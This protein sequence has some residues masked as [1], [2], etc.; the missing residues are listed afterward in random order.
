MKPAGQLT[1]RIK[2]ALCAV[3]LV[4]SLGIAGT[5]IVS[6]ANA[7]Q[8]QAGVSVAGAAAQDDVQGAAA[9]T[10]SGDSAVTPGSDGGALPGDSASEGPSQ[11]TTPENPAGPG[12]PAEPGDSTTPTDPTEPVDPVNPAEPSEPT[13]PTDPADPSQPT[14][15]AK[16]GE[17]E[18]PVDPANP[19]QPTT[20]TG[21]T[22]PGGPTVPT[23]PAN[24]NQ[25]A[26]PENPSTP[27]APADAKLAGACAFKYYVVTHE[28]KTAY[29]T[30]SEALAAAAPARAS[31]GAALKVA[32][33]A[34]HDGEH[35]GTAMGDLAEADLTLALTQQLQ[36][37]V[38]DV[39]GLSVSMLRSS[40]Q[41]AASG[42]SAQDE[43][44]A[45]IALAK[46]A[47]ADLLL[48]VH[49]NLAGGEL[50]CELPAAQDGMPIVVVELALPSDFEQYDFA[51]LGEAVTQMLAGT[52]NPAD[53]NAD[54]S[55]AAAVSVTS[56][57][58]A[59]ADV[60][61]QAGDALST[62]AATAPVKVGTATDSL[63]GEDDKYEARFPDTP[64]DSWY[65]KGGYIDYVVDNG[66]MSGYSATGT[67][68]PDDGISREQVVTILYRYAKGSAS[69][70]ATHFSDVETGQWYTA[71]VE[72]A[73]ENGISTGYFATSRFG[74]G[75]PITR[76]D[77]A[78]ML[79][80]FAQRCGKGSGS[81]DISGFYDSDQVSEYAVDAMEWANAAGI[82][83]GDTTTGVALLNPQAPTTRAQ[84]AKMI[85]VLS[86]DVLAGATM[87]QASWSLSGL[88]TANA[89]LKAGSST[90]ATANVSG[91]GS[92]LTYQFAWVCSD[93]ST[94][95][96]DAASSSSVD[97]DFDDPGKYTVYVKVTDAYGAAHMASS[98]VQVWKLERAKVGS[99]GDASW[100][101][102]AV[103]DAP[104]TE[105][106]SFKYTWKRGWAEGSATL[107]GSQMGGESLSVTLPAEDY[108]WFYAKVIDPEGHEDYRAQRIL[109]APSG[110]IG[111]QNPS[112]LYQVSTY[113]VSPH[114]TSRGILSY[115][116]PSRI[117]A[118]ATRQDCV[119]AFIARAYEYL[120][121]SYVWNYACAPGVGVDCVG[122]VMQ[123][124]YAVGMDTKD[125]D[126]IKCF[127]P[128][129]HWDSG[130]DG[131]HSHDAN[132]LWNY[133]KIQRISKWQMSRGDLVFWPG[134]VAI[135]L[136]ND[137]IIQA[138]PS[139]GVYITTLYNSTNYNYDRIS[140]VGRLFAK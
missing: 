118:A 77:F 70:S 130:S 14:D 6:L 98:T 110:K 12:E 132:N 140:G 52:F 29:A 41:A 47:G 22:Q 104:S 102:A 31:E 80:R 111:W 136:G 95:T 117:G 123:C 105:G 19:G 86:R 100:V 93:G 72:W 63:V 114:S 33:D 138:L 32:L 40:S 56:A 50:A 20:P 68:G 109:Y 34:A 71:A 106:Y 97:L 24:P 8:A 21:P 99:A 61:E 3:G 88:S 18:T 83:T 76:E 137:Q 10:G 13:T 75:D 36:R 131:W 134:H 74:V 69:S 82:L 113:N 67:F 133:G 107:V 129:C 27:D 11:P 7:D 87:Q 45:R 96:G 85:T 44:A 54:A 78:T 126:Y 55:D 43:L 30:L 73:Y 53:D 48:E 42:T 35:A 94:W 49:A 60:L 119:E 39:Q 121:T 128:I 57:R 79:Y 120:G 51:W 115:M 5:S 124:C 116:T 16:P 65:V 90:R 122:L 1:A 28:G 62:C 112:D 135:Y 46:E 139:G 64:V 4:A 59:L 89:Y 2:L 66:L 81:A 37:S 84:A 125:D 103:L 101:V 9:T 26:D 127:D 108:Y 91:S 15:P 25:P 58:S 23:D 17:P 38:Q 92:G